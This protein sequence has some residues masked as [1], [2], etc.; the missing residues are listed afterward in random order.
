[1]GNCTSAV[2]SVQ[3]FVVYQSETE[4]AIRLPNII[5]PNGDGVNDVMDA[6]EILP[7]MPTV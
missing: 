7:H 6:D 4:A 2:A 5:T 1:M 3:P